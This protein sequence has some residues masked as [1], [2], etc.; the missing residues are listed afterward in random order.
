M[1]VQE[2]RLS[3][4]SVKGQSSGMVAQ[5]PRPAPVDA[6]AWGATLLTQLGY[7]RPCMHGP[8]R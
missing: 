5:A 2:V 7:P 6:I 8:R 1:P 4:V 3:E